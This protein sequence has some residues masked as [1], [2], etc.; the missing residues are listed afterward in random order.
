MLFFS[1]I[2]T[3]NFT[4]RY[5]DDLLDIDINIWWPGQ[6]KLAF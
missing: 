4:S 6:S 1:G 5:L 3:F 2:A